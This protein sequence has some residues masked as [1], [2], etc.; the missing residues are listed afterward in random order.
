M[1]FLEE[2]EGIWHIFTDGERRKTGGSTEMRRDAA[3]M[4]DT[5]RK[6]VPVGQLL[7]PG[8]PFRL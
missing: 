6:F 1:A 5:G 4:Q 3:L 7:L 8:R 2:K